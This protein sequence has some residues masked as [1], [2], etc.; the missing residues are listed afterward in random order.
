MIQIQGKFMI[1]VDGATAFELR[2][3][4]AGGAMDALEEAIVE[5]GNDVS[6]MRVRPYEYARMLFVNEQLA[7]VDMV[8][9]LTTQDYD[10][11]NQAAG[12]LAKKLSAPKT[13]KASTPSDSTP[14]LS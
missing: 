13:E 2:P 14:K 10:V 12:E 1:G 7:S 9:G 6:V 11:L 3:L 8:L 4:T 5:H